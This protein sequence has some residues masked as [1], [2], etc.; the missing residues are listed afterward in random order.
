MIAAYNTKGQLHFDANDGFVRT[1]VALAFAQRI[2][3]PSPD[4]PMLRDTGK[5]RQ[6]PLSDTRRSPVVV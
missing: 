3:A 4:C 5:R 6:P 1:V 2:I